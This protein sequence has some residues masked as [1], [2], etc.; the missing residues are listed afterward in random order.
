MSSD[1]EGSYL[2]SFSGEGNF[3][4]NLGADILNVGLGTAT[5]GLVG[6]KD[7]K[8]QAGATVDGLKVV[9]GAKAAEDATALA[10][11][12]YEEQKAAAEAGRLEAQGQQSRDQ[13]IQSQRAGAARNIT[14]KSSANRGTAI[15]GSSLGTEEKDFLGL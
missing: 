1:G 10:R 12:Q 14:S 6:Y 7:G 3:F 11:K 2:E 5:G 8:I 9:T 15:S 13:M 4:E